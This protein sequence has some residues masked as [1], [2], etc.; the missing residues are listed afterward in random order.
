[1]R[2]LGVPRPFPPTWIDELRQAMVW[3]DRDQ[4]W[5]DADVLDLVDAATALDAWLHDPRSYSKKQHKHAWESAIADLGTAA[6]LVGP[7]LAAALGSGLTV[8]LA[9]T[10]PLPGADPAAGRPAAQAALAA[11]RARWTNPAV[12]EAAWFDIADA[13]R[14]PGTSYE[15]IAAR[16]D[17]FWRLIRTADR[18]A[19]ELGSTIAGVL[20]DHATDV[21][22][23]RVELGDIPGP[24]PHGWPELGDLAGLSEAD[25]MNLARRVLAAPT[26]PVHHV[27]WVAF[28]RAGL[29]GMVEAVGRI[30]FYDGGWVRETLEHKSGNLSQLP[31]ELTNPDSWVSHEDLPDGSRIVLARVDLGTGAFSDAPRVAAEQAQAVVA[32]ASFH[33]GDRLWQA[34]DGY[35]H[36]VD[37]RVI[38]GSLFHD[39]LTEISDIRAD[40]RLTGS[41]LSP[42]ATT[43][44]PQLPVTDPA[45]TEA[46]DV[47]HWWHDTQD[48]PPLAGVGLDVR[49]VE[50]VASRVLA[51]AP[52]VGRAWYDYLDGYLANAWINDHIR[53]K[54]HRVVF[55]AV[56]N[57]RQQ[58]VDPKD[59]AALARLQAAVVTYGAGRRYD[60]HLDQ[61][62]AAL[63]TLMTIYPI[64]D[65]LGRRINTLADHLASPSA[66]D[67]WC[68][69]LK[70]R[71]DQTLARLRRTRNALAHGGPITPGTIRT[72]HRFGRRLAGWALSLTL[73]GLLNG[74]GAVAAHNAVRRQDDA[75]RAGVPTAASINDALFPP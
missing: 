51:T 27:V 44:G 63:P 6:D 35:L 1:M 67:A 33:A 37:G 12:V 11:L 72:V 52:V 50:W 65:R 19:H 20:D 3:S 45:L 9:A 7:C 73:E 34:L 30:T 38:G 61:A 49:V 42:L 17:L 60:F 39:P 69:T 53:N 4:R 66:L 74:T 70:H 54:L 32:V 28:D 14:D 62:L 29:T 18:N 2:P 57:L 40:L 71:W 24:R 59:H 43:L 13:C 31:P 8:A 15:T 36:A 56:H 64:H 26:T 22:A 48:R 68:R 23:A 16:R 46:I 75:W 10:A 5:S 47:L 55:Q 21:I 58:T 25:R 41:E